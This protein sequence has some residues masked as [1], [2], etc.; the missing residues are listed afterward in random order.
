M[1][2]LVDDVHAA[3]VL[4][5]LKRRR[6]VGSA[7]DARLKA[8]CFRIG[9]RTVLQV[10]LKRGQRAR[11]IRDLTIGRID[12]HARTL[13]APVHVSLSP[14]NSAQVFSSS[15]RRLPP[16]EQRCEGQGGDGQLKASGWSCRD[17]EPHR[18]LPRCNRTRSIRCLWVD[19]SAERA[20]SRAANIPL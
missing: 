15:G 20:A 14:P 9:C 4:K 13:E 3:V 5:N 6:K 2:I 7:R 19:A 8:S 17:N 10:L 18:A 1:H 11:Q 16:D 12:N